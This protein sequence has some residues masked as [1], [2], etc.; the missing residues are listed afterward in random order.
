MN[1]NELINI[2]KK[3][4][5][6]LKDFNISNNPRI[7]GGAS[8]ELAEN[9]H[10]SFLENGSH[11]TSKLKKSNVG[12]IIIPNEKNLIEQVKSKG[13]GWATFSDPRLAFAET[14]SIMHPEFKP[15][16]GIHP[17]AFLGEN[18]QIAENVY[19]G[20]NVCIGDKTEIEENC[21]IHPG[22]VIYQNVL[23]GKGT[24]IHANT[25]I[26]RN[27]KIGERCVLNSNS[28]IGGEG[29]GFVPT[30]SG[31]EKMPQTGFVMLENEV[32]I[33]SNTTIDRPAV[34][35][36]LVGS[37]S[38]IDNLVQIG[39]GVQIGKA[40]AMASQVGIAGGANL[41]DGVILAGQVGVGN[42]VKVGNR[43]IA[44]SKCGIHAD[45]EANQIVSGFPA[46]SNKAWLRCSASF[47]KLPEI[48]KSIRNL[49]KQISV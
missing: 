43:V 19:V 21:V 6:E 4:K 40:C 12:A 13:I 47:K 30:N 20:P 33:G 29:F 31:W 10:I 32:E 41:G 14:L 49:S 3:S 11:L 16:P 8:L 39:H 34:G 17:T 7:T 46:M 1:F 38:K 15:K 27:S 5:A 36:T 42:R 22:V 45:V 23:I 26:H 28:V 2:L 48:A 25:V 35:I 18:V 37:G 44:S 9:N 24:E